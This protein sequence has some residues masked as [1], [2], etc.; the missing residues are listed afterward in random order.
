M[1]RVLVAA[2]RNLNNVTVVHKPP[3]REALQNTT[4]YYWED[5]FCVFTELYLAKKGACCGSGCR[6]CPYV[7]KH[8][9]GSIK[10]KKEV[11]KNL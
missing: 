9:N 1:M 3:K 10:L 5:G 2:A 11:L 7:P 6:H 4:D 8:V